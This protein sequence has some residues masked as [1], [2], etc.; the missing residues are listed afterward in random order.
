MTDHLRRYT[1]VLSVLFAPEI[2]E[3]EFDAHYSRARRLKVFRLVRVALDLR[4][5]LDGQIL[6]GAT[7]V[8]ET[9]GEGDAHHVL[10]RDIDIVTLRAQ[11]LKVV[12][13]CINQ[14]R[15]IYTT[16]LFRLTLSRTHPPAILHEVS[17]PSVS[18]KCRVH[19]SR[20]V[21]ISFSSSVSLISSI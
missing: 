8:H 15:R 19:W 1:A 5:A 17:V 2:H 4:Y 14:H 20:S 12:E 9:F 18:F 21:H 7:E 3:V 13:R 10:E 6:G 16:G 11:Q